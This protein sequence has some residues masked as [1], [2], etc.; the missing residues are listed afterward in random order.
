MVGGYRRWPLTGEPSIEQRLAGIEDLDREIW[1][2]RRALVE[3]LAEVRQ[4]RGVFD[5][6]ARA[7]LA[8][9]RQLEQD[10]RQKRRA[11][12]DLVDAARNAVAQRRAGESPGQAPA[13]GAARLPGS[14]P[15]AIRR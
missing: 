13:S 7:Q 3:R 15:G 10:V 14:N 2:L 11:V 1:E 6:P 12:E 8:R 4:G 9:L 5:A